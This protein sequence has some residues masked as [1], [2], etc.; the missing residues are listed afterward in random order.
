[1]NSKII[2]PIGLLLI[3]IFASG[4]DGTTRTLYLKDNVDIS[5]PFNIWA[6]TIQ[7]ERGQNVLSVV[8]RVA[9]RLDLRALHSSPNTWR[10]S[11]GEFQGS[12]FVHV[13][14]LP[15]GKWEGIWEIS[16]SDWPQIQRSDRSI[17]V[18]E[19]ILSSLKKQSN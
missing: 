16:I 13:E 10:G 8:R 1:M 4:C 11:N 9:E 19:L 15:K 17:Q 12:L 7:I 3:T 5:S 14:E 2:L 6:T 18:E